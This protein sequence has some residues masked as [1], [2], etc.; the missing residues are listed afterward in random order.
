MGPLR[1][2]QSSQQQEQKRERGQTTE[3][4]QMK[5]RE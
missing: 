4:E 5:E 2:K 1:E 3:P